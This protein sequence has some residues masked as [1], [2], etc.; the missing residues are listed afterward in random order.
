MLQ[1]AAIL[2]QGVCVCLVL[3]AHTLQMQMY[4]TG[5]QAGFI[6]NEIFGALNLELLP[7]VVSQGTDVWTVYFCGRHFI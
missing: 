4:D 7:S 5:V 1:L 6:S 3:L 2:F